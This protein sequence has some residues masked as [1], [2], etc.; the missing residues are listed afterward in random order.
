MTL[1]VTRAQEGWMGRKQEE[2]TS[3][4][5]ITSDHCS[6]DEVLWAIIKASISSG[7]TSFFHLFSKHFFRVYY[8]PGTMLIA[9]DTKFTGK[10]FVS[11][12]SQPGA[13]LPLIF[14]FCVVNIKK[15][16]FHLNICSVW[17]VSSTFH[18]VMGYLC[19][20]KKSIQ[21]DSCCNGETEVG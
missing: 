14:W 16:I 11:R 13:L 1:F 19:G 21:P 12:G 4:F 5:S 2:F 18:M 20:G 3:I 9:R 10:T 15:S 8:M 7:E 6:R 17:L